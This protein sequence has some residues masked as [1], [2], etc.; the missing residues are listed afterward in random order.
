MEDLPG[1]GPGRRWRGRSRA[2]RRGRR[3]SHGALRGSSSGALKPRSASERREEA[4]LGGA[5]GVEGLGHRPEDLAHA[6]RLRSGDA[7]AGRHRAGLQT[8]QPPCRGGGAEDAGGAGD[9]PAGVVVRGVHPQRD[10]AADLHP[11]RHGGQA[12]PGRRGVAP[13]PGPSATGITG[14]RRGGRRWGSG[15]RRSRPG[16]S[17][18]RWQAPPG[19][20]W[21][22]WPVPQTV[23][24]AALS[25]SRNA[26]SRSSSAGSPAACRATPAALTRQ[27]RAACST[28]GGRSA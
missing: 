18:S 8:E 7:E 9:A 4:A 2:G 16:G 3:R 24:R 25:S 19:A 15:C 14:A 20:G 23:A 12:R 22:G 13:R 5:A 26:P 27:R 11:Q 6:R 10:A 1:L 17:G 21:C 28:S